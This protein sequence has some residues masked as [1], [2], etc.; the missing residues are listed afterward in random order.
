MCGN[1]L[2]EYVGFSGVLTS[3]PCGQA[4]GSKSRLRIPTTF[5]SRSEHPDSTPANVQLWITE[6]TI[7]H[8]N[9]QL[10]LEHVPPHLRQEFKIM[11]D[12]D[13]KVEEIKQEIQQRT[14]HLMQHAAE[15]TRDERM[16]QMEQIQN[17]FKKGKEISNDKVSR[18]ESAYELVDKQI[19]RLDAD[20]FE[21]KKALAE[22]ELRKV[23]K[24]RNKGEQEPVVSPK[25]PATAALA[26]AL[27]NN[28]GEVLDMPVDPNEPTYC[29]CQQVSYGEM[30][31]CDNHDCPIEWFHFDCVGLVNK[32]RGKWYCPQCTAEEC[33]AYSLT[34]EVHAFRRNMRRSAGVHAPFKS[35]LRTRNA[36]NAPDVS[37]TSK[38]WYELNCITHLET[39]VS[40]VAKQ[41]RFQTTQAIASIYILRQTVC[42]HTAVVGY[43]EPIVILKH[44][45]AL[46]VV[47]N[48]VTRNSENDTNRK[49]TKLPTGCWYCVCFSILNYLKPAL[50]IF[51]QMDTMLK[52][53]S[54]DGT[55][56]V[57]LI[58]I[59]PNPDALLDVG[60]DL[61]EIPS[62]GPPVGLLNRTLRDFNEAD[63]ANYYS[64]LNSLQLVRSLVRFRPVLFS[65]FLGTVELIAWTQLLE[66]TGDWPIKAVSCSRLTRSVCLVAELPGLIHIQTKRK[67]EVSVETDLQQ[68]IERLTA[69]LME[70]RTEPLDVEKELALWRSRMHAYNEAKDACLQLFGR[71]A[72]V[73][74]CLVRDLYKEYG[75]DLKD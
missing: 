17:L 10:D 35:P 75:L 28:P 70:G 74:G 2:L 48:T 65:E 56:F 5:L 33:S 31:A 59:D 6:A 71:L 42:F 4:F 19:R 21:F 54:S 16:G 22:K 41:N 20:M 26:L 58:V 14:T 62:V 9:R 15:M 29:V 25:I 72:H 37:T 47:S 57:D 18:A 67:S 27:T 38:K 40:S 66:V 30:V 34:A 7:R 60:D 1:V 43:L 73:K 63:A 49:R 64:E 51:Q 36:D 3:L 68:E 46:I 61:P 55:Y 23:K 50:A 8:T 13:Q 12:L 32:P 24:S 39:N 69:K 52:H 11:R 45:R 53:A 44:D